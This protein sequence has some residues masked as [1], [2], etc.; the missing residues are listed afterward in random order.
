MTSVSE[1]RISYRTPST[2]PTLVRTKLFLWTVLLFPFLVTGQSAEAPVV[3]AILFFSPTCPHCRQVIN[4]LLIPM[5]EQYGDQLQIIGIDTSHQ[6]G[7]ELYQKAIESFKIPAGR[8]GVPTLIVGDTVLVGSSEIPARFPSL[9]DEGLLAGGIGWPD[10]LDL[11]VAIPDL[12]PPADPGT[13]PEIILPATAEPENVVQDQKAVAVPT[14][15]P[16]ADN[17]MEADIEARTAAPGNGPQSVQPAQSPINVHT[18]ASGSEADN[19]AAD[20]VGFALAAV[21]LLSTVTALFYVA[22]EILLGSPS[23]AQLLNSPVVYRLSW[24]V[25]ALALIGL[26]VALYLSYVELLQVEAVCG[27]V[28]ECNIVQAS[29]YAQFFGIPIAVL[30]M[31]SYIAIAAFWLAQRYLHKRPKAIALLSLGAITIFGTAFSAYLTVLELFV[32]RAVCAW[33][34]TSTV[35]TT[36]IMI[37]VVRAVAKRPSQ[38][39]LKIQS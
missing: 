16:A 32:I 17:M 28:G 30:G 8:R 26:G 13:R 39:R 23:L 25:P 21:V 2:L 3:Q 37:L 14:A 36:L 24:A 18:E 34:L 38:I 20:T 7:G 12:P 4:E 11:A 19:P 29:P 10:I 22:R 35:I 15:V 33:C 31:L 1:K 5:Q 27:P 6:A 9:V